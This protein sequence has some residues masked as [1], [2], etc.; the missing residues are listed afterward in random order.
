MKAFK[1]YVGTLVHVTAWYC[2]DV[3]KS[4]H[5]ARRSIQLVRD[6]HSHGQRIA[7][8]PKKKSEVHSASIAQC[9]ECL[10]TNQPMLSSIIEDSK[11]ISTCPYAKQRRSVPKVTSTPIAENED[12]VYFNQYDMFETQFAFVGIVI[13]FPHK[14]GF[15]YIKDDDLR[16]FIHF[17]RCIGSF[18][19]SKFIR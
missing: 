17:W 16:G 15:H 13:L 8:S 14:F 2:G 9:G 11:L 12:Y 1:R 5:P 4:G 18:S 6:M 7:N 19:S 3:W 10:T